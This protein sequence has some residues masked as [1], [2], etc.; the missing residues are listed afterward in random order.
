MEAARILSRAM[1][2]VMQACPRS[3]IESE[4]E[5]IFTTH[6]ERVLAVLVRLLGERTHA[7]EV[8]NEVFWKLYSQRNG[9]QVGDNV[10]GWLYRTATRAGIDA[11]RA[12][13][14]RKHYEHSAGFHSQSIQTARTGPLQQVL[15]A[16]ECKRV[17]LILSAMKPAQAQIL[18]LRAIGCSYK[19]VAEALEVSVSGVG[20]LLNRA[21]AEFRKR[22]TKTI[23]TKENV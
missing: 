11:L 16:E 5:V 4:F 14:R 12:E 3:E 8:T 6:Y 15:R 13:A 21:E 19:E 10:G 17:R 9:P 1:A 22:Y 20:T 23:G 18:L 2:H 7:E